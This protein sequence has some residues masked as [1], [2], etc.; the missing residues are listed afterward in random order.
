M[1]KG[2][3]IS[4]LDAHRVIVWTYLYFG[5]KGFGLGYEIEAEPLNSKV[6]RDIVNERRL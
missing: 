3:S 6:K 2:M 1:R 5:T 4:D